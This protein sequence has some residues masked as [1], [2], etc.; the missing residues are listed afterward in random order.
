M[1]ESLLASL[2]ARAVALG[3]LFPPIVLLP[4]GP[5]F[6]VFLSGSSESAEGM[7]PFLPCAKIPL[8]GNWFFFS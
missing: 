7:L 3:S 5:S 6:P 1:N 4:E 2:R 8:P